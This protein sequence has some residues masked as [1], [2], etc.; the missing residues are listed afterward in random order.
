MRPRRLTRI[1]LFAALAVLLHVIE[2]PI[3]RPL[4]WAKPGLA[5]LITLLALVRLGYADAFWI[6]LLRVT[7]SGLLLGT[8]L[9]PGF[10]LALSGGLCALV[11]MRV[12]ERLDLALVSL[13]IGG[14]IAHN[15]GQLTLAW[16]LIVQHAGVF[17]Q[18]PLMIAAGIAT[19]LGIGL[20]AGF[21][22]ARPT[23][24]RL[25]QLSRGEGGLSLR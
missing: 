2:L 17:I 23:V 6:V 22:L 20:L 10:F 25:F 3:P 19:G 8:F 18:L 13:S 16:L 24:G 4:P 5:N 9:S 15:L 11:A 21:L 14:A 12:L 7:L 1:A